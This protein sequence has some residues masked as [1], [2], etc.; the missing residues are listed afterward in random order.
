MDHT[1][2]E[3]TTET[4][5]D[6]GKVISQLS[7]ESKNSEYS[8][9]FIGDALPLKEL[10]SIVPSMSDLVNYLNNAGTFNFYAKKNNN[11]HHYYRFNPD[12]IC[13]IRACLMSEKYAETEC[14]IMPQDIKITKDD[15]RQQFLEYIRE[16]Y[17][18]KNFDLSEVEKNWLRK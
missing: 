16:R 5:V 11:T 15:E 13:C 18:F 10:L 2:D 4:I 8:I 9:K 12:G 1:Y 3:T 6:W 14:T 7:G 17:Q